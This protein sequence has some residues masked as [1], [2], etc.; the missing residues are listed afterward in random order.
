MSNE[1]GQA[2]RAR[3][4]KIW[5]LLLATAVAG[6]MLGFGRFADD[7]QRDIEFARAKP[8]FLPAEW[9][10][11]IE[12]V[13]LPLMIAAAARAKRLRP[14]LASGETMIWLGG[15]CLLIA[16]VYRVRIYHHVTYLTDYGKLTEFVAKPSISDLPTLLFAWP[17]VYGAIAVATSFLAIMG[18]TGLA[19][20]W[21]WIAPALCLVC[22]TVAPFAMNSWAVKWE[23]DSSWLM[24]FVVPCLALGAVLATLE[25]VRASDRKI[26]WMNLIAGLLL[27]P[28]LCL[29]LLASLYPPYR[30][31]FALTLKDFL[32]I[33]GQGFP[34]LALGDLLLLLGSITMLCTRKDSGS[35]R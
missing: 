1:F 4:Y 23:A 17:M 16:G 18:S 29:L 24:L 2:R 31:E 33:L 30:Y 28:T 12:L 27:L 11:M 9:V 34:L 6:A 7:N 20:R 19:F 26:A 25:F 22:V 5:T 3:Q 15:I 32:H 10:M 8:G 35:I 21:R 13:A 14:L